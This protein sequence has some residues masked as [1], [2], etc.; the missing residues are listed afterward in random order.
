[1][2]DLRISIIKSPLPGEGGPVLFSVVRNESYF[3]PH[4]LAHYRQLGIREFWFLDNNSTDATPDILTAAGDCG[5]LRANRDFADIVDGLR[6]GI[7]ARSIIPAHLFKDRWVLNVDADEFL[8]LPAQYPDIPA[9][10]RDLDAAGLDAVRAL[11]IDF[12]PDSLASLGQ[13]YTQ[14]DPFSVCQN[15][16]RYSKIDWP[17]K[18]SAPV[19]VSYADSVRARMLMQA[20]RISPDIGERLAGYKY[21]NINKVPLVK[22]MPGTTMLSAHRL[23]RPVSDQA[24]LVLAHF[25]FYPGMEQRVQ[26]AI[27]RSVYWNDS[28]EY[29]ILD[30]VM[31]VLP[32]WQLFNQTTSCRYT[33][34]PDLEQAGM[35]YFKES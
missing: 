24:Q 18:A 26:D 7:R 4:F 1:M 25:K 23:N 9:L 29:K 17:D 11:M 15:F 6:F 10:I 33:G 13:H 20:L 12:F 22:W 2:E 14:S 19:F 30:L 8:V 16:D 32:D 31:K 27:T 28:I 21:P 34:A 3:L 5:M 35:L